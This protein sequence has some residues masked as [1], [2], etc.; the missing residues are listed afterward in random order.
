MKKHVNIPI[1]IPHEGCPNQCVFCNQ[2]TIT[3]TGMSVGRDITPEIET[4][5][6]GI[7]NPSQY[8]IEIAFFGGSFTGIDR[9][10]MI[11]LLETASKYV[12][13]GK[14][15]SIRLST[16]PDY[17]DTE[18]LDI[19]E[20][21]RATK[22][23]L[24]IQ[25]MS[26]KVLSLSKRGH[27][28]K[29]SYKACELIKKYGFELTGQMMLGLPGSDIEDEIYTAQEIANMHCDC[30]RIYPTVVFYDTELCEMA[31]NGVYS[32]IT[33]NEAVSRGAA[34]Y[35]VFVGA[36]IK[37]LRIGLQS[38]EALVSGDGVYGGANHSAL[39]ELIEGEY[40]FRKI[41]RES[42]D[43]LKL[44]PVNASAI[45]IYCAPGEQ[46]KVAGQNKANKIKLMSYFAANGISIRN[47]K[48]IADE[49]IEKN[50]LKYT[51]I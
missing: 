14:V 30:A 1:F 13:S 28:A 29:D 39:G 44:A 49:N 6:S 24:G 43:F 41:M 7:A 42:D 11:R 20:F 31:K 22:V 17:I 36:G 38:T 3:G 2:R 33:V 21:Y 27:T 15:S 4:V 5:L 45:T 18:I 12:Y 19:L 37:L 32:P 51:V 50:M 48:I 10:A 16:R 34:V 25:S 26:D 46:S 47:I 8:D 9:S 40:Y 23:E 35:D